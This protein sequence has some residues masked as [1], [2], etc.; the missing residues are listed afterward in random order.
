MQYTIWPEPKRQDSFYSESWKEDSTLIKEIEYF[1]KE[2]FGSRYEVVLFPSGRSAIYHI[3]KAEN[4]GRRDMVCISEWSSHCVIEAIRRLAMPAVGY[5]MDENPRM[6]LVNHQWGFE[7]TLKEEFQGILVED[8][9]DS[10]VMN[11][12]GLFPNNGKYEIFSLPKILGT[13]FG[14]VLVCRDK[15]DAYKIRNL[16][17]ES[18]KEIAKWQYEMKIKYAET[19]GEIWLQYYSGVEALNGVLPASALY[20]I[21]NKLDRGEEIYLQRKQRIQML[22]NAGVLSEG[23]SENMRKRIPVVIPIKYNTRL[24]E[25]LCKKEITLPVRH[26]DY[27]REGSGSDYESC[28]VFPIH[29]GIS[30]LQ[31][32]EM[33]KV[34]QSFVI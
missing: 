7:K 6:I 17:E 11:E 32:Q 26:F 22:K 25:E 18:D 34:F 10:L 16:L 8:S 15:G 12:D 30:D 2:L 31:F 20:E 13:L 27:K 19:G 33:L 1:L 24:Y 5:R 29:Q 9:C 28:I 23:L 4:M 14:G 21:K 3:I